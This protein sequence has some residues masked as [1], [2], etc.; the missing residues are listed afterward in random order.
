MNSLDSST[1]ET[2]L[3]NNTHWTSV[4][5]EVPTEKEEVWAYDGFYNG[6]IRAVFDGTKWLGYN[7]HTPII[8]THWSYMSE[9][10]PNPEPKAVSSVRKELGSANGQPMPE[11]DL[12]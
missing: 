7:V 1:K 11:F 2:P 9:P 6:R 5:D 4:L 12:S 8:V 3:M 10:D